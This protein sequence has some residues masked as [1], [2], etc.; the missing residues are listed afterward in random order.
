MTHLDHAVETYLTGLFH[1]PVQVLS[2]VPL[3][4]TSSANS[5][6]TYG[7]GIP[8]RIDYQIEGQSP[9]RAILHSSRPGPFGHEHMADRA[10]DTLLAFHDYPLLPRHARPLDVAAFHDDGSIR[11]LANPR[12]LCLLTEYVDGASYHLDLERIRDS[13]ELTPVDRHR[14]AA[15]VRY[16]ASIH[17][18]PGPNPALYTRR[19]RELVGHGECIMGLIDSYPDHPIVTPAILE[20]IELLAVEWRWRLRPFTHRLC[21]VHGDFHPWN[22]LFSVDEHFHLLDRS[23]GEFGE[24]ADDVVSLTANYLFFSLQRYH[25]LQGPFEILF[26]SFWQDYLARTR[27]TDM[28][29]LAAPF[30]AFRGLVMASPVWYP[31]LPDIVRR[32]LIDFVLAVLRAEEFNPAEVNNYCAG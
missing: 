31:H 19:I 21:Q 5:L 11:S 30:F 7:Y 18:K 26:Q 10:H 2:L 13:G 4:E 23:R 20:Q 9:A 14:A 27:D 22:I 32:K 12:E 15:L 1:R 8:L 3:G 25:R 17:S 24:P 29:R 28:L 16:L 6:K